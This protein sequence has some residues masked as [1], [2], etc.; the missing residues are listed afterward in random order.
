MA[1]RNDSWAVRWH[2]SCFVHN[3]LTLHPG[4]SLVQNIGFDGINATHCR[5]TERYDVNLNMLPI[6]VE[7]IEIADS[8]PA[9]A[10]YQ[11]FH[12]R[13]RPPLFHARRLLH[14]LRR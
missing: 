6:S 4:R 10:I 11:E 3:L 9:R 5:T 12:R 1:G 13:A 14:K 8:V 2:A 7:R